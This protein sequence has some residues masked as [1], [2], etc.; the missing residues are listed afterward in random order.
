MKYLKF[1]YVDAVTEISVA[2]HP[3]QNGHKFPPVV[4]LTF[5]IAAESRYPTEVPH[6]FGTCPDASNTK[7]DG[8]LGVFNQGDFEQMLDDESAARSAQL[9]APVKAQLA[10]LDDKSVRSMREFLLAKFPNDPLMPKDAKGV[11]VLPAL[12]AAAGQERVKLK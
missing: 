7:V 4:G 1:T 10:D 5:A 2:A 6:F 11:P 9:A 8:V 12:G 3:A